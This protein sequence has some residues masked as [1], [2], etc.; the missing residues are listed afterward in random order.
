MPEIR[1]FEIY[2]RAAAEPPAP[3]PP[4]PPPAP[5]AAYAVVE[6]SAD[7]DHWPI[8]MGLPSLIVLM[9]YAA[10]GIGWW[11]VAVPLLVYG[12][13]FL[14]YRN[15]VAADRTRKEAA[16]V[17][18][19]L[20]EMEGLQPEGTAERRAELAGAVAARLGL[21]PRDT[22]M[23]TTAAR[24]HDVG[25]VGDTA[26]AGDRPGFDAAAVARWSAEVV[27]R[28]GGLEP[29]AALL[30]VPGDGEPAHTAALRTVVDTVVGYDEAVERQGLTPDG[31][32]A[33]LT[34]ARDESA[35]P[36]LRAL[37]DLVAPPVAVY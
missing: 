9:L 28:I 18:S 27:G 2:P 26:H 24:C 21:A 6:R 35:I 29:V 32:I 23:V 25:R 20:P 10:P 13:G 12:A 4:P 3:P 16:D 22:D 14:G 34:A 17:L 19:R 15:L 33:H 37:R 30:G 7:R 1:V 5:P 36:A 8:L 31:A 11:A